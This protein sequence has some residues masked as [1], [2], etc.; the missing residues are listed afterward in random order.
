MAPEN[1]WLEDE[2]PFGK[3]YF[4]GELLVL[5]RLYIYRCIYI[6]VASFFSPLIS[7]IGGCCFWFRKFSSG[8]PYGVARKGCGAHG[9][10]Y[11]TVGGNLVTSLEPRNLVGTSQPRWNLVTSLGFKRESETS[12][13]PRIW[14]G[15]DWGTLGNIREPPPIKTFPL[16]KP[17]TKDL[18]IWT[19][20]K[21]TISRW[22]QLKY[23]LFSPLPGEIIRF[24]YS[25]IFQLGWN[26]QLGTCSKKQQQ[27]FVDV[28]ILG[29]SINQGTFNLGV[30]MLCVSLL[31]F[32]FLRPMTPKGAPRNQW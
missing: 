24:D 22:W 18:K 2:F 13:N 4:R 31:V 20:K 9:Y 25:N 21:T 8:H 6:V 19:W 3:A 17:I 5:G 27:F 32:F 7:K 28:L 16:N 10:L 29:V 11:S 23:L 12:K 14:F 26:H 15:E 1:R 30:C